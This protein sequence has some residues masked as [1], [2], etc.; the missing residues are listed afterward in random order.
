MR[1]RLLTIAAHLALK[2]LLALFASCL[3]RLQRGYADFVGPVLMDPVAFTSKN[4][5]R[6][7]I[8]CFLFCFERKQVISETN[9][10]SAKKKAKLP[11]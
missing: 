4:L 3:L 1:E 11:F 10:N 5:S 8:S 2:I 6:T 9:R 7:K